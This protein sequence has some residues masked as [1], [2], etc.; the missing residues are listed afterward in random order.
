M[1][2]TEEEMI[3]M[4]GDSMDEVEEEEE[5][6]ADSS[7][8]IPRQIPSFSSTANVSSSSSCPGFDR[9]AGD[10]WIYP[11]NYPIRGYQ[12]TIVEKALYH[13]TLVS[14]PTGLGKTFIAAVVMY[15]FYR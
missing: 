9:E 12:L 14:L 7:S 13:N 6:A 4:M 5:A 8:S 1:D 10:L 2:L 15:N 11:T 3:S